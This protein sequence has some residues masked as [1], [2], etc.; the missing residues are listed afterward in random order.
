MHIHRMVQNTTTCETVFLHAPPPSFVY[1]YPTCLFIHALV[2]PTAH[3]PPSQELE[4][5]LLKVYVL[6]DHD[7][8][9]AE[10]IHPALPQSRR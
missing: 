10:V 9:N 7:K 8:S 6:R 4:I 2:L 5:T 3:N 1:Q